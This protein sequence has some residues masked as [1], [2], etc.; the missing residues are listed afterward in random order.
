MTAALLAS[1]LFAW[2]LQV[3]LLITAGGLLCAAFRV[4]APRPRLIF[5]QALLVCAVL[6]PLAFVRS[7]RP[8]AREGGVFV[9]QG[10]A[11]ARAP[12]ARG[13]PLNGSEAVLA[14]I[15]AGAA[16]RLIG[17]ALGMWRLRRMQNNGER[18]HDLPAPARMAQAE[19]HTFAE[20]YINGEITGPV[21]Y[22]LRNPVVLLPPGFL[23]ASPDAQRSIICHELIHVRRNDWP[24]TLV[25]E[26][27]RALFWFHPAIWWLLAQIQ[28]TREQ[29]VDQ[30]TIGHTRDRDG[31]LQT[32]LA[33]AAARLQPDLAPAPL[34]LRRRHLARRVAAINEGARMSMRRLVTTLAGMAPL[35]AAAAVLGWQAFPLTAANP[36]DSPGVEVM[37]NDNAFRV[38]HRTGVEYPPAAAAAHIGGYV[39]ASVTLDEKGNVVDAHIVSG[40]QALRSAVLSSVL[41]WH[42]D[43]EQRLP[44][45]RTFEIG[46]RFT[47]PATGELAAPVRDWTA[48]PSSATVGNIDVSRLPATLQDKAATVLRGHEGETMSAD[49]LRE[50]GAALRAVDS[51]LRLAY[52]NEDGK[53]TLQAVL[54]TGAGQ[55]D[56]AERRTDS[57]A[58][59]RIRVGGNVQ[60]M[61]LVEK[62]APVYPAEAKQAHLQGSV[63]FIAL[64]GDDGRVKKLTVV[65][66]HPL[67]VTA[68]ED[69]VRNWVYRPTLL[70]GNPVEVVTQ[71]DVNF[72]L[73][74]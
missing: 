25:E 2:S 41:K 66:G 18:I 61:N 56:L 59:R 6:L 16:I 29:V 39:V 55:A 8:D 49:Q 30:E 34:F 32:L 60:Q 74:Q 38:L 26:A 17:I 15:A 23:D 28:L 58:P 42:F 71:I 44:E 9:T 45:N 3:L 52:F 10:P 7:P 48:E 69:A 19:L 31:Y 11:T 14:I 57:D 73:S 43:P 35:F 33:I 47:A 63:R 64:I 46:V 13:L 62:V 40:P 5:H 37:P 70:N 22:G 21:T 12:H 36:V 24:F 50:L 4:H 67:L 1:N 65:S 72:T 54:D 51:H 68:A 27:V 20:F 53:T